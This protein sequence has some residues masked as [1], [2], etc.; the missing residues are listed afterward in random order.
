MSRLASSEVSDLKKD[1]EGGELRQD[2][3]QASLQRR[4]TGYAFSGEQGNARS[5]TNNM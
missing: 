1:E 3:S 5:L 4:Y 2:S